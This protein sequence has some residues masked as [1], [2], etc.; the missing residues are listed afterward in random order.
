ML[1]TTTVMKTFY[2]RLMWPTGV[3][4]TPTTLQHIPR[5]YTTE[6]LCIQHY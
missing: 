6:S 2:S 5:Q 3:A 1:I 4:D